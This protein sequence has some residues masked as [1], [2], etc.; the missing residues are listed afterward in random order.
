MYVVYIAQINQHN[1]NL[2]KKRKRK[3]KKTEAETK[4]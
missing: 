1:S 3:R 4:K 2:I